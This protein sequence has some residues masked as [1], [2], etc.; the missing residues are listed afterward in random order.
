VFICGSPQMSDAMIE[1]LGRD[2]FKE[3][4]RREPGQIHVEKYWQ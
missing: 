1:I 4:T 2:G 3:D